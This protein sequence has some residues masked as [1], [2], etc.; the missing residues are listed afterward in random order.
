MVN[1]VMVGRLSNN[2]TFE[3]KEAKSGKGVN[4]VLKTILKSGSNVYPL[5]I[6]GYID[7]SKKIY[8]LVKK[9]K[10]SDGK[11]LYENKIVKYDELDSYRENI[12]EF[13]KNNVYISET[14]KESFLCESDFA[15][16]LN[17]IIESG[18][19][20]DKKV[21]VYGEIVYS[22]F[23]DKDGNEKVY[24]KYVPKNIFVAKDDEEE[25]GEVNLNFLFNKNALVET[26]ADGV[27]D[28][29]V[30]VP[31][32]I[33][34]DTTEIYDD[35]V[36]LN[37]NIFPDKDKA[38]N[39]LSKKLNIEE[40]DEGELKEF[41]LKVDIVHGAEE[42]EITEEM[43]SD[44]EKELL[45]YGLTTMEDLKK[46]YGNGKGNLVR[47]YVFKGIGRG[48]TKK[49]AISTGKTLSDFEPKNESLDNI[50]SSIAGTS[51][52]SEDVPF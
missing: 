2:P 27:Y 20:K 18:A 25:K 32:K 46:Q 15:A 39:I 26:E 37:F 11:D 47:K 14:D 35:M 10:D 8:T 1:F 52:D 33:N 43:L 16:G 36:E 17:R 7:N 41:A 38:K 30:K 21:K 50:L 13:K 31:I 3:E 6:R 22:K 23:I 40:M 45:E 29:F 28:L 9:G 12:A 34:K 48:Y 51:I 49:D 19:L 4:T 42:V 5:E 44:E 24:K